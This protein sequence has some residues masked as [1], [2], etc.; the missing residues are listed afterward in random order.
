MKREG[1]QKNCFQSFIFSWEHCFK[2]FEIQLFI[3]C[4]IMGGQHTIR[5]PLISPG[6]WEKFI[7]E[8][9]GVSYSKN[10][11]HPSP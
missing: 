10:G 5:N 1:G 7:L 9:P 11:G 8:A 3:Y 6:N 4:L 2:G